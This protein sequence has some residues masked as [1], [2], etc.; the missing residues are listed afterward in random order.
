MHR[1][2]EP[3]GFRRLVQRFDFKWY[4]VMMGTG[5]VSIILFTFSEIYEDSFNA[6]RI[7]SYVFYFMNLGIFGV[8]F[9]LTILR[10]LMYPK[11]FIF[12]ISN[13]GQSMYLAFTMGFA[14]IVNV[15]VN[16]A[17]KRLGGPTWPLVAWRL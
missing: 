15:T 3:E 4:G 2:I 14:T 11:L 9:L 16:V 1:I 8:I 5:I 17:V 13:P 7:L 12:L 6:L 10:Y